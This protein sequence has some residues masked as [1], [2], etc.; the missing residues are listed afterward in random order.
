MKQNVALVLSSGGSRGLAHI[1]VINELTKQGFQISSVSGS[2]IGA[3]IGG[4]HAMDKLPVYTTWVKRLNRKAIWGLMDFT[5]TTHGLLKGDKVFE[6][7]KT[8]IPDM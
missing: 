6:T 5:L 2:S 3:F 7:L 1:G 8:F 4:L